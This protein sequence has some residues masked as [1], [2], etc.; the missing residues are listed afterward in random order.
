VY[1]ACVRT[2]IAV[3]AAAEP[4][5]PEAERGEHVAM[6]LAAHDLALSYARAPRAPVLAVM[7]GYSG[8]GK[9]TVA[10]ELARRLPAILISS[11]AVRKELA[12]VRASER[13]GQEHYTEDKTAAVYEAIY[14]RGEG[15]LR[16][17]ENVI[18]DATFLSES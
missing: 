13:L 18:L 17:G 7:C 15:F 16:H 4:E 11:D 5:I 6:A 14:R 9:S 10:K 12:G 2:K 8:T 3:L 1:R